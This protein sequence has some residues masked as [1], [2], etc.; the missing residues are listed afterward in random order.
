MPEN[1][2]NDRPWSKQIFP[3]VCIHNNYKSIVEC[4]AIEYLTYKFTIILN[5]GY[6]SDR[7]ARTK[8]F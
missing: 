3:Y 1:A 7:E 4:F 6:I 2:E 8:D 5:C